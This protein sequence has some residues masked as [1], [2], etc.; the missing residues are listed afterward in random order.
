VTALISE[1]PVSELISQILAASFSQTIDGQPVASVYE[2]VIDPSTGR[3][4]HRSPVATETD[5]AHAVSS[6]RRAQPGWAALGW[7]ERE[8]YLNRLADA[9]EAELPWL[10]TL[11]TMEQGMPLAESRAGVGYAALRFRI[12]GKVRVPDEVLVDN[13]ERRVIQRWKPRGVVAAIAPWNGPLVLGLMKVASA[14]ISGNSVVLKPS[15]LTPLS[16]LEVG[17]IARAILPPG[18]F[19]VLGGGRAVGAAMVAHPGFDEVSFTGSTATGIAI[20]KQAAAYLRPTMLELGGNDAAILLADGSVD[21]LV[22]MAALTTFSNCGQFCAAIKRIYAPAALY[23]A[24]CDGLVAAA[25]A[26]P[27]GNGFEDGVR[28]G[29]IQNKAQFDKV[30]AIVEDAVAAGGRVL[31]G[32][33]PLDRDGYFYPPT[34]VAGLEDG[35]RLV[36]EE[37][38]GPVIPVIAYDDVEAVIATVNAGP[39]GLTGSIWTADLEAGER[40]A[41]RLVVGTSAVNQ[42]A[43][44]GATL[45][46]PMIKASGM[47]IDYADYGVKGGMRMQI[48]NIKAAAL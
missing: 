11:Q 6:A 15:E 30:C 19:N 27:I 37:Q 23:D 47:G 5:I 24:V 14:L 36:D 7:D 46:F 4:F 39:Y 28:M 45:P 31:T 16:T 35:V 44:L 38:F 22:R 29:P 3:A 43:P 48:V 25:Q 9:I 1:F 20:A 40:L 21:D 34:V 32:G 17:R 42:H 18:V 26:L 41:D 12:I 13:D 8:G 33:A 10:A 2:D